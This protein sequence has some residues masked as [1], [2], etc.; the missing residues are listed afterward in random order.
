MDKTKSI[1]YA[2]C[3]VNQEELKMLITKRIKEAI[4][5]DKAEKLIDE[6][7]KLCGGSYDNYI[8]VINMLNARFTK[9]TEEGKLR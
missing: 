3:A 7:T 9:L 4:A 2:Q 5:T 1:T 6:I 8:T